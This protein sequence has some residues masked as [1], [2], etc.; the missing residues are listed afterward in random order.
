MRYWRRTTVDGQPGE[1]VA[2]DANSEA[3]AFAAA[4]LAALPYDS[5][6][7]HA[8]AEIAVDRNGR[9]EVIRSTKPKPAPVIE[10][11]AQ[12][13]VEVLSPEETRDR[14]RSTLFRGLG[15]TEPTDEQPETD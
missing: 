2:V 3:E 5:R 8:R 10:R 7:Q 11:E 14:L 6:G 12:R 9:R 13:A 15:F 1:W 4:C